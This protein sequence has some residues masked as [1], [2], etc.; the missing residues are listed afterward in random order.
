MGKIFQD[1][2]SILVNEETIGNEFNL[3]E[4]GYEECQPTKPYEFIPIDYWVIHYCIAGEGFFQILDK[5]NHIHPGDI[6]MI[7]PNTKN[8]YYPD[9]ENPWSY[10]WIGLRG[11]NV[12][13]ILARCGL[14]PENYVLHHKVDAHLESLFENVYDTFQKGHELM[15]LGSAFY[16]LDYLNNNVRNALMD[17]LTPGEQYLHSMLGYIHKNYFNNITVSDIAADSS[18]DRTYVFKLFQKYMNLSPSQY[19]QHY[20]LDKACVLLRKSSMSIT[21]IGYAVGFQQSPYFTKLFTQ[22]MGTTPSE[23]RKQFMYLAKQP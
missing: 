4:C 13:N 16:L 8:K 14:S 5:Q 18:I 2:V 11:T 23:Y 10:R 9:P 7:P 22:Y 21:D 1:N 6:F 17:H 19:L 3:C 20:R 15:S 12:K